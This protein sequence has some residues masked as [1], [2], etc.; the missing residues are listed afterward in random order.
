MTAV[1]TQ[2]GR[3]RHHL[4]PPSGVEFAVEIAGS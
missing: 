4:G 1:A 2:G 3:A